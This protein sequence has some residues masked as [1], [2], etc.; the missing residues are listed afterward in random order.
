ML[1]VQ[2]K[3]FGLML[4]LLVG[5]LAVRMIFGV[6]DRIPVE[7]NEFAEPLLPDLAERLAPK[8]ARPD[9]TSPSQTS[10][11]TQ[12]LGNP[13]TPTSTIGPFLWSEAAESDRPSDYLLRLSP[14]FPNCSMDRHGSGQE[15]A[16]CLKRDD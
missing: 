3:E 8:P 4:L 12:P 13:S 1:D 16:L 6:H 5:L 15:I 2:R 10:Q 9:G 11:H 7:Q 14:P